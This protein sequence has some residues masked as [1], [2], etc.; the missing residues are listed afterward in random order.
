MSSMHGIMRAGVHQTASMSARPRDFAERFHQHLYRGAIMYRDAAIAPTDAY[1]LYKWMGRH[2]VGDLVMIPLEVVQHG[3]KAEWKAAST[4]RERWW[5]NELRSLAPHGNNSVLPGRRDTR[6]RVLCSRLPANLWR[7]VYGF[8][9]PL[10]VIALPT[11]GVNPG[12]PPPPAP[13]S[14]YHRRI[15]ALAAVLATPSG[16]DGLRARM[17]RGSGATP[18]RYRTLRRC[19]DIARRGRVDGVST[20]DRLAV[21]EAL[22]EEVR[23]RQQHSSSKRHKLCVPYAPIMELCGLSSLVASPTQHA[24]LPG[25]VCGRARI[26][27]A[28]SKGTPIGPR[29]CNA[30]QFAARRSRRELQALASGPCQCHRMDLR[31]RRDCRAAAANVPSGLHVYTTDPDFAAAASGIPAA[32]ALFA[33]GSAYRGYRPSLPEL[34]SASMH[35]AAVMALDAA[36]AD[37]QTRLR[38]EYGNPALDL[39]PW[40]EHLQTALEGKLAAIPDGTQLGHPDALKSV[41]SMLEALPAAFKRGRWVITKADKASDCFAVMCPAVYAAIYLHELYGQTA[42][43]NIFRADPHI[44]TRDAAL[45]AIADGIEALGLPPLAANFWRLSTMSLIPK[46]HKAGCKTRAVT[47]SATVAT[48]PA[49]RWLHTLL[50]AVVRSMLARW[51]EV[52][53][54]GLDPSE[55]KPWLIKSSADF[56]AMLSRCNAGR[57]D[58]EHNRLPARHVEAYD[59][60]SMFSSIS[61]V[62]LKQ[63][64]R[65]GFEL[66][67]HNSNKPDA[68][69]SG[70][71]RMAAP[72]GWRTARSPSSWMRRGYTPSAN[73]NPS[74][75]DVDFYTAVS[76][77]DFVLDHAYLTADEDTVLRQTG[78]IPMGGNASP[79]MANIYLNMYEL[80]FITRLLRLAALPT[81]ADVIFPYIAAMPSDAPHDT[82]SS[83]PPADVQRYMAEQVAEVQRKASQRARQLLVHFD[84][85]YIARYIDDVAVVNNPYFMEYASAASSLFLFESPHGPVASWMC[86]CHDFVW[87]EMSAS[88]CY[89]AELDLKRSS[90]GPRVIYMDVMVV[91]GHEDGERGPLLTHLYDKRAEP[92][93]SFAVNPYQHISSCISAA[94]KY[95][96]VHSQ[97]HRFWNILTYPGEFP[98]ATARLL[99][100]L[101]QQGYD[102]AVMLKR[103]YHFLSGQ[104]GGS[105]GAEVQVTMPFVLQLLAEARIRG[106]PLPLQ[107]KDEESLPD[108]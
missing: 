70:S 97:L 66:L 13:Y 80:D 1:P 72:A 89:P 61:Q 79:D 32:A 107:H 103:C 48:T 54:H 90:S 96:T 36:A 11:P 67:W 8:W 33:K 40:L 12:D 68:C 31:F 75:Y 23:Q 76:L 42:P 15:R 46:L 49:S 95:N 92:A 81:D 9:Y 62:R 10:E 7:H 64:L 4:A 2:G 6:Y 19:L 17:S 35:T 59:F 50:K 30:S 22:N 16:L 91:R 104:P 60:A 39:G 74:S 63:Q 51:A 86:L 45:D 18:Y 69:A 108:G 100:Q 52:C 58:E 38:Q 77:A 85:R 99:F 28:H 102:P 44:A 37:L 87:R 84:F 82:R 24:L 98:K 41:A 56:V 65:A 34:D 14:V 25:E 93:L 5:V 101:E 94:N 26:V 83:R 57:S 47:H 73:G 78:G 105:Q 3:K 43:N 55:Y 21:A 71:V 27:L 106:S 29:L 88:G 20:A 53:E